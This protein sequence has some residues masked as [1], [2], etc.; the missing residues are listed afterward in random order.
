MNC[1]RVM[2][3]KTGFIFD[4]VEFKP[5]DEDAYIKMFGNNVPSTPYMDP[6][7]DPLAI[8]LFKNAGMLQRILHHIKTYGC[9]D[10]IY[11]DKNNKLYV[12]EFSYIKEFIKFR[13]TVLGEKHREGFL[14]NWKKNVSIAIAKLSG[15]MYS[16]AG[17]D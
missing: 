16:S 13:D 4:Y 15:Q 8:Y 10:P 14:D 3:S 11:I 1:D 17:A 6:I 12:T 5:L 7:V 2:N 9:V